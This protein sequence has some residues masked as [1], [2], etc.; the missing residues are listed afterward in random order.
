MIKIGIKKGRHFYKL[1]YHLTSVLNSNL[2]LKKFKEFRQFVFKISVFS[3]KQDEVFYLNL[4]YKCFFD[5]IDTFLFIGM[6]IYVFATLEQ[7]G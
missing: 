5:C 3:A 2:P 1:K 6:V 4:E 7:Q